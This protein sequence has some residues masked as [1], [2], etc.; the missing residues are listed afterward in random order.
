MRKGKAVIPLGKLVNRLRGGSNPSKGTQ[1]INGGKMSFNASKDGRRLKKGDAVW[2]YAA[3]KN[4]MGPIPRIDFISVV[5]TTQI[6]VRNDSGK[7]VV[8]ASQYG[9]KITS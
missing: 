5:N 2:V 4:H 3:P 1:P 7:Q 9:V 6:M 8:D